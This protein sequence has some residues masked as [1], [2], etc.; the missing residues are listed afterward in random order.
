MTTEDTEDWGSGKDGEL[1]ELGR[2]CLALWEEVMW[3]EETLSSPQL[4]PRRHL[5]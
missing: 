4:P 2:E 1:Q 3:S 5:S